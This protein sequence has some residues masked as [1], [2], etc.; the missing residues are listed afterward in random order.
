MK[1]CVFFSKIFGV[2][3]GGN[4]GYHYGRSGGQW[5]LKYYWYIKVNG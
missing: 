4:K 5:A 2:K 1:K 3:K